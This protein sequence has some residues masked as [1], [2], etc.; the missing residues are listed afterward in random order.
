MSNSRLRKLDLNGNDYTPTGIGWLEKAV[1]GRRRSQSITD[2]SLNSAIDCNHT[3]QILVLVGGVNMSSSP[4]ENKLRKL[5]EILDKMTLEDVLAKKLPNRACDNLVSLM[6]HIFERV[7]AAH[8]ALGKSEKKRV[9]RPLAIQFDLLRKT[10]GILSHL[11]HS[12][13]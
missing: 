4:N 6:P 7:E 12:I 5:Y 10:P 11:R 2:I 13:N 3:C 1:L 8:S 9:S